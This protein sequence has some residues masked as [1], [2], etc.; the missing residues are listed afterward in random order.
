MIL[1][2]ENLENKITSNKKGFSLVECVAALAIFI[3]LFIGVSGLVMSLMKSQESTNENLK[4]ITMAQGIRDTLY[5]ENS[6]FFD[7]YL[8]DRKVKF[9]ITDLYSIEKMLTGEIQNGR[10]K[11]LNDNSY[12]SNSNEDE[13]VKYV[14]YLN[15]K[16]IN[17][18][19]YSI[20]ITIVS[21][22]KSQYYYYINGNKEGVGANLNIN[23]ENTEGYSFS[24]EM[25]I[26]PI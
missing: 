1:I 16:E 13:P 15:T 26:R 6:S 20:V 5:K 10:V 14:V 22:K 7:K 24:E 18:N 4:G 17:K 12:I 2:K 11:K 3:V 9:E 21:L 25:I 23:E 19:L 8:K